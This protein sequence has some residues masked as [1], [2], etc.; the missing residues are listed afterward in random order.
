VNIEVADVSKA[1][2]A[3]S[4]LKNITLDIAAGTWLSIV[5]SS[6]C[7]K[8]SLLNI[9]AGILDADGGVVKI[10]SAASAASRRACVAY[11]LQDF[12]LYPS[13][14]VRDNL[15]FAGKHQAAPDGPS[16]EQVIQELQIANL[17]AQFPSTLSGGE[18]QRV[19]LGRTLLLHRPVLL[20]DEPLSNVDVLSR[21]SIRRYLKRTTKL[22]QTTTVLVTHDQEDAISTSDVVSVLHEGKLLQVD[23]PVS[24][25]ESAAT[26]LVADTFGDVQMSWL[27]A[28]IMCADQWQQGDL[29][30]DCAMVGIR[31]T[32]FRTSLEPMPGYWQVRIV[33]SE[34]L[35]SRT[36]AFVQYQACEFTV[37]MNDHHSLGAGD[38]IWV[39]PDMRR[40]AIYRKGERVNGVV[41]D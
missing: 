16:V 29:D 14:T 10:G 34:F 15:Q 39:N 25:F 11:L 9:V 18:R 12:P 13:L 20:L 8:S 35:G 38:V 26:R 30:T 1:F 3:K 22:W 36:R 5:G 33:Q 19:A 41:S 37:M 4:V 31:E 24:L 21:R 23:G 17:M 27:P 40:A 7:G 2:G 6:G 28:R 32:A